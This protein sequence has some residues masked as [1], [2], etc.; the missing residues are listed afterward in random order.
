MTTDSGGGGRDVWEWLS[1]GED[2]ESEMRDVHWEV[3]GETSDGT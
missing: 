1:E 2:R 3:C